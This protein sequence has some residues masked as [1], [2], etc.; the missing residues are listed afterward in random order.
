MDP[1]EGRKGVADHFGLSGPSLLVCSDRMSSPVHPPPEPRGHSSKA[2]PFAGLLLVAVTLATYWNSLNVP[3]FF[4]DPI[5][6]LDNP[7]IRKLGDIGQVLSPP[8]NGSGVTGRPVVNLSLALNYALGGTSV[9]GYHL[10]NILFHASAGLLLF[11]CIRRTLANSPR[12]QRCRSLAFPL[13]FSTAALWLLHPLQ[14]E[15]VT[16]V[17]QRTELLV[18]LFYLLTLYCFIRASEQSSR[19]W[20]VDDYRH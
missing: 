7:T 15:S 14:T 8:R 16:C 9:T 1:A 12:L 20:S 3:F 19:G 13:A 10:A 6:I 11:G 5:G 17:I 2:V 18:G 4:D